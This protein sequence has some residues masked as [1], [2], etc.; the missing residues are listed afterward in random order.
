ML[1]HMLQ[2][3]AEAL[4]IGDGEAAIGIFGH[5][6]QRAAVLLRDF[7]ADQ[8]IAEIIGDRLDDAGDPRLEAGFLDV[9]FL[10]QVESQRR[11]FAS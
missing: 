9:A 8:R 1:A 10:G 4:A 5:D 11:P 6:L 3:L 2:V 7:H